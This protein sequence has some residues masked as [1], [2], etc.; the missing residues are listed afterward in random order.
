MALVPAGRLAKAALPTAQPPMS[1][2]LAR[3]RLWPL[4]TD[5]VALTKPRVTGLVKATAAVARASA[6][7]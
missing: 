4:V 1:T 5:L 3:S 6:L 7:P 2:A